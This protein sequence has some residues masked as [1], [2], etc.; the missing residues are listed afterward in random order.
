MANL[1]SEVSR[2]L[3]SKEKGDREMAQK[4]LARAQR[5]FEQIE[6]I[7]EMQP[8]KEELSLLREIVDDVVQESPRYEVSKSNLKSYF[9]PFASRVV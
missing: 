6:N 5:I 8:R 7:P 4:C 1:G 9:F 3:D 2:L